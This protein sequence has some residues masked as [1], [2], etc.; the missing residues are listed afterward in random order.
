MDPFIAFLIF[1]VAIALDL[2]AS[3][4]WLGPYFRF[5]IPIYYRRA[6][7]IYQGEPQAAAKALTELFHSRPAHPSIRF[8]VLPGKPTAIA[9]QEAMFENRGGF[10]YLPVI[11]SLA[12]LHPDSVSVTGSINWYVIFTLIYLASRIPVDPSLIFIAVVVVIIFVM[13]YLAQAGINNRILAEIQKAP[14]PQ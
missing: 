11:H 4:T 6:N 8:K 13:S 10:K 2:L 12:R 7:Y 1:I 9:F 14:G 3:Q 5:G